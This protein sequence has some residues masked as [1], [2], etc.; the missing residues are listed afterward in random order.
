M[1]F[2]LALKRSILEV[3]DEYDKKFAA[4]HSKL[5][6]KPTP[7]EVPIMAPTDIPV[8]AP[9]IP[10]YERWNK[11]IFRNGKRLEIRGSYSGKEGKRIYLAE[12]GGGS[13]IVGEAL[14]ARC[15]GPLTANRWE[16]L[17]RTSRRAGASPSAT[18]PSD[19]AGCEAGATTAVA[20]RRAA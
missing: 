11:K 6:K 3:V 8:D 13:I 1:S 12:A 20:V 16:A 2:R 15:I 9:V 5:F 14:F 17:L 10:I 19:S 7:T 18:P 4:K